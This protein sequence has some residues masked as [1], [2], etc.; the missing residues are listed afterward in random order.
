MRPEGAFNLMSIDHFRPG[1]SFGGI[2]NDHGPT[3]AHFG[4]FDTALVL[5]VFDLRDHLIQGFR[6]AISD[7]ARTSVPG[8]ED[9]K[10]I[11]II[12]S[13]NPVEMSVDE[14]LPRRF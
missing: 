6:L 3:G 4:S 10:H 12:G 7:N 13:D 5:D 1:P 9:V 14:I 11:E 8:A 2:K